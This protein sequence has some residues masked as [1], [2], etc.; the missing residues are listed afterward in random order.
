MLSDNYWKIVFLF[1]LL[2][3]SALFSA[4]ETALSSINKIKVQQM[5]DE[6]VRGIDRVNKLIEDPNKLLS[7][8]L[9][10]NNLVN[11]AASSNDFAVH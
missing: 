7:S 3:L 6:K 4:S 11:I 10:G 2:A 5:T 1:G 9:I 8:I